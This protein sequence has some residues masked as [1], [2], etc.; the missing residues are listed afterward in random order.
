[1]KAA[2]IN[3]TASATIVSPVA[4]EEPSDMRFSGFTAGVTPGTI[5]LVVP[6][7]LQEIPPTSANPITSGARLREGGVKLVRGT[8]CTARLNCGVGAV[9]ISGPGSSAFNGISTTATTTLRSGDNTMTL[10]GI[11]LRYGANGT[12]GAVRGPGILNSVGNGTILVGG[13]LNVAAGQ[14]VGAYTGSLMISVD[15]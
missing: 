2:T 12:A 9:Q 7:A 5:T 15:Y 14:A 13:V 10:D 1:M 3:I 6:P 11:E 4:F 8:S